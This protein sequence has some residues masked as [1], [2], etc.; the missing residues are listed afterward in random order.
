LETIRQQQLFETTW[1]TG[2][3]SIRNSLLKAL[4]EVVNKTLNTDDIVSQIKSCE[5][6]LNAKVLLW[7]KLKSMCLT[8]IV[9]FIISSSFL[10]ILLRCQLSIL[11]GELLDFITF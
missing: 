3:Q 10:E 7:E 2:S 4:A 5:G 9:I 8:K 11:T 1:R 6:Q